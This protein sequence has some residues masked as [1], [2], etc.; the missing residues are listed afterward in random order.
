MIAIAIASYGYHC[1]APDYIGL[2]IS[3]G[4]HPYVN[5]ESEAWAGID[6]INACYSLSR[7]RAFY[8]NDQVF[9]TG[10]SQGG[11]SAMATAFAIE[12]R[13]IKDIDKMVLTAAAPMSGP[14]SISREM[15]AFTMGDNE[16]FFCGYL[17]SVFLSAKY[18]HFDLLGTTTLE[19]IFKPE[20][21]S[22][23]RN[24][25]AENIDLFE[26]NDAM[27]ALLSANGGK[28]LPKKMFRD[29]VR[30]DIINDPNNPLQIAL[31]RMD[32]CNWIPQAPVK[33]IYCK[34]DDQVTYRNAV[35]TDSL[36]RA[37]GALK[38][39]KQDVLSSADHGQC[40]YPALLNMIAFFNSYQKIDPV[41]AVDELND[42]LVIWP[43]PVRDNLNIS[44]NEKLDKNLDI[45][46]FDC[47]GREL[48][49]ISGQSESGYYEFNIKEVP[50][51]FY[52]IRINFG[53]EIKLV[54]KIS[55]VK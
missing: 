7:N 37:G 3:K 2:G 38:V 12:Q 36:M 8:F 55:V 30:D 9:V 21:A 24:F 31:T 10:Y 51:G 11:H 18:A 13:K 53:N 4:I 17:G 47:L 54:K 5:P 26:L 50:S 28:I 29:E 1:V 16:Y 19:D 25:E 49:H 44:I 40:V 20:F 15:K 42:E 34:A 52:F 33:M 22:L 48:K 35:Y 39:S 41:L 45:S 32:V 46:L 43:N 27:I 6:L 14:Y 23:I